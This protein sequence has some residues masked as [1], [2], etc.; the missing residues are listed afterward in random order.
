MLHGAGCFYLHWG[1]KNET[2]GGKYVQHHGACGLD[3]EHG[4]SWKVVGLLIHVDVD[5]N[6]LGVSIVMGVPQQRWMVKKSWKIH[7]RSKWMMTGVAL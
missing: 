1:H 3:I 4:S 7:H 6:H 2:N 5:F